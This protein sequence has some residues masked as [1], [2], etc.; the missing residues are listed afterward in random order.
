MKFL[1]SIFSN[2]KNQYDIF[3]SNSTDYYES[4]DKDFLGLYKGI[5][6][7]FYSRLYASK[8]FKSSW[9]V[10]NSH[11]K[12]DVTRLDYYCLAV[13]LWAVT[14][15]T[16]DL[17]DKDDMKIDGDYEFQKYII[18]FFLNDP[19]MTDEELFELINPD[20]IYLMLFMYQEEEVFKE[21][22]QFVNEKYNSGNI[23]A[24]D[25]DS[26]VKIYEKL[27]KFLSVRADD[28]QAEYDNWRG[29]D[30][31]WRDVVKKIEF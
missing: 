23:S 31:W 19:L 15:E 26:M 20:I 25:S 9:G 16:I 6:T 11:F 29:G 5:V 12:N 2:K 3:M 10:D 30:Q 13:Y 18:D 22:R 7:N 28:I 21:I 4:I 8:Q 17:L 14:L 1:K 24:D 27:K